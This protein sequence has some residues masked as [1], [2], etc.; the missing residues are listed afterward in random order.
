MPWNRLRGHSDSDSVVDGC[1]AVWLYGCMPMPLRFGGPRQVSPAALD[2]RLH[3]N[4][5]HEKHDH[6]RPRDAM[7]MSNMPG[8][9]MR[10][11]H[12]RAQNSSVSSASHRHRLQT[13]PAHMAILY[14]RRSSSRCVS[15][16]LAGQV[17]VTWS[18]SPHRSSPAEPNGPCPSMLSPR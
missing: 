10:T 3:R 8:P 5:H 6:G 7:L 9:G 16:N 13:D 4:R 14:C 1:M 15:N 18:S 17:N 12:S 11:E 2:C